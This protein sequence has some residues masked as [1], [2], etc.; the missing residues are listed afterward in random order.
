[1]MA[2][3][4][5]ADEAGWKDIVDDGSWVSDYVSIG[6]LESLMMLANIPMDTAIGHDWHRDEQGAHRYEYGFGLIEN[7]NKNESISIESLLLAAAGPGY[8]E[9][10]AV[11]AVKIPAQN[12]AFW[13]GL[14]LA[15]ETN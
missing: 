14:Q 3:L 10:E 6:S 11:F 12:G 1:M 2:L 8:V 9:I 5:G 13:T 4:L 15:T 7:L